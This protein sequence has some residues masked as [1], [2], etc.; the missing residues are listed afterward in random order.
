MTPSSPSCFSVSPRS[1]SCRFPSLEEILWDRFLIEDGKE[2]AELCLL[3]YLKNHWFF[4][5]PRDVTDL[6][7]WAFSCIVEYRV[8]HCRLGVG[9]GLGN[10]TPAAA[11]HELAGELRSFCFLEVCSEVRRVTSVRDSR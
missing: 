2:R 8:P 6:T 3:S 10:L 7:P 9:E 1:Q 11:P 4:L 5:L